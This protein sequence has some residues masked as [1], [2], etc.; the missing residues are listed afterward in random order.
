MTMS[1][2]YPEIFVRR[3]EDSRILGRGSGGRSPPA[4]DE[5]L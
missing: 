5:L 2:V 4:A 3:G 1:V